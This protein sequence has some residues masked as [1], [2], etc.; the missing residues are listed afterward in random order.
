[1]SILAGIMGCQG[2]IS[3]LVPMIILGIIV[4]I[5]SCQV[6]ITMLVFMMSWGPTVWQAVVVSSI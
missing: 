4:S 2:L 5:N 1:M 6:Q 3:A